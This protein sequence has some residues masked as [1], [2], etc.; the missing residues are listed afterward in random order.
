MLSPVCGQRPGGGG[1]GDGPSE[2]EL[3]HE[4]PCPMSFLTTLGSCLCFPLFCFNTSLKVRCFAPSPV[5]S[6]IAE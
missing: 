3:I 5:S 6:L 2:A 1:V 4:S